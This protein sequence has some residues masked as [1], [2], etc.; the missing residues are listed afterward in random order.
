VHPVQIH[1][2]RGKAAAGQRACCAVLRAMAARTRLTRGPGGRRK[3]S[4]TRR[5]S[6]RGGTR[7]ART[8]DGAE[9][10]KNQASMPTELP[11]AHVQLLQLEAVSSI[12][13]ALNTLRKRLESMRLESMDLTS[14]IVRLQVAA[15]RTEGVLEWI[16]QVDANVSGVPK[17]YFSPRSAPKVSRVG[18]S[19]RE[20]IEP[21]REE[22]A[23]A[24]AGVGASRIWRGTGGETFDQTVCRS[25]HRHLPDDIP[26]IQAFGGT[27]FD[28]R[29]RPG[30]EWEE[31]GSY[32]FMLPIL[33]CREAP[34]CTLVSC[35]VVWDEE[36]GL[37]LRFQQSIDRCREIVDRCLAS[38]G[39]RTGASNSASTSTI[40]CPRATEWQ[41][42]VRGMLRRLEANAAGTNGGGSDLAK[43]V[44]ARRTQ[45]IIPA[46]MDPFSTLA[47]LQ[48]LDPRAYQFCLQLPS[49]T[50]FFGS[51]PERLFCKTGSK[52]ASE[53]M[54]GTRPRAQPGNSKA[55]LALALDLMLSPKEHAEFSV[56]QDAVQE[57]LKHLC[58]ADSVRLEIEKEV[59]KQASV[60]H[61]YSRLSGTLLPHTSEDKIISTLHPTPAVCGFPREAARKAILDL[62][63]FDRGFYAGPFGWIGSR[64][65]E[66][67]VAIRS[68]L[69]VGN[70]EETRNRIQ[71]YAGVGI[72]KS[73]DPTA[74]WDELD[75]KIR[76]YEKVLTCQCPLPEEPNPNSL[77]ARMI[78]EELCRL[79]VRYFC[80]AP[81]SRST[82][83]ALAVARNPRASVRT[84]LDERSLCFHSLGFSR[85][86]GKPA[87]V[88]T[89][90]GTA[91][92]NLL[93]AVVEAHESSIPMLV[94][95]AD[96][97]KE[98]LDNGS[99]QTIH[100]AGIFG[101]NVRYECDLP[102]ATD[103]IPARMLLTTV[104]QAVAHAVGASNRPGP[105]HLNCPFR[106]PL[107]P[108]AI[109]WRETCLEGL[110]NWVAS[111]QPFTRINFGHQLYGNSIEDMGRDLQRVEKGII[112]VGQSTSPRVP[113]SALKL[114]EALGWPVVGD[115][116]SGLRMGH[117][118]GVDA[119]LVSFADQVLLSQ[120]AQKRLRPQTIIQFG[121]HLVS[122]RIQTFLEES[123]KSKCGSRWIFVAPSWERHDP[124]HV[125]T[126]RI[127]MPSE[128]FVDLIVEQIGTLRPFW[129]DLD[130]A[131]T[132]KFVDS[133]VE[134]QVNTCLRWKEGLT[135]AHVANFVSKMLP[136]GHALFLGNSMPIRD[137]DM[138]ADPRR[139]QGSSGTLVAANRGAS[140]IDGVLSTACGYAVGLRTPATLVIG[141]ASFLHDTNGLLFLRDVPD[142]YP[143][144]VV[145]VNNGGGS[146]F[147]Y[148]PVAREVSKDVFETMFVV[149]TEDVD[150]GMLCQ[151]HCTYHEKV[152]C[153]GDFLQALERSWS[154]SGH[155]VIEVQIDKADNLKFHET[156]KNSIE[157]ALNRA[158]SLSAC[159]AVDGNGCSRAS[160][161]V[162]IG[163]AQVK[164]FA[165]PL[166][167]SLTVNSNSSRDGIIIELEGRMPSCSNGKHYKGMG[168][169]S[170]LPG[171]HAESIQQVEDQLTFI[172]N[173]INKGGIQVPVNV[174]LLDGS[175]DAWLRT[176][177]GR[178]LCYFL[179]SVRFG[180]ESAVL[181][182]L[183]NATERNLGSLIAGGGTSPSIRCA[184]LIGV[185]STAAEGQD[186]ALSLVGEGYSCV[187]VKVGRN[188]NVAEDIALLQSIRATVG[189][190]VQLRCDANR[191]WSLEEALYFGEGVESCNLEYVEE[192]CRSY[193]DSLDFQRMSGIPVAFDETVDEMS[194]SSN[195]GSAAWD[196]LAGVSVFVLKPSVLGGLE[197]TVQLFRWAQLKGIRCVVSSSFEADVG[198][199]VLVHLSAAIDAECITETAHGL[200]TLGW[201]AGELVAD[202]SSPSVCQNGG[203]R[204][205]L[206][207]TRMS[208][209]E[210][211]KILQGGMDILKAHVLADA[212]PPPATH[213][214]YW[215]VDTAVAR[216][217]FR[218]CEIGPGSG[219][220][221]RPTLLFLHGFLGC[222][223]DWL[224]LMR[225]LSSRFRCIS[226]DLPGHG[227]SRVLDIGSAVSEPRV[228]GPFSAPE[229]NDLLEVLQGERVFEAY[230]LPAV[231]DALAALM[232]IFGGQCI[233]VGYSMG[234]RI[235]LHASIHHQDVVS[236]ACLVSGSPGVSDPTARA[237]RCAE[238]D[239]RARTIRT[240]G[241]SSFVRRWYASSMW[242]SMRTHPC[243]QEVVERRIANGRAAA[244]ACAVSGLSPGR[245]PDLWPHLL[246]SDC[247]SWSQGRLLFVAGARDASYMRVLDR[248]SSCGW[249]CASVEGAGHALPL[250]AP[251]GLLSHLVRWIQP[252]PSSPP[253]GTWK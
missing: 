94:L 222:K 206:G 101:R 249:S 248:L 193:L 81:G 229:H 123:C 87:V 21:V 83:L 143:V 40:H 155:S 135:E 156:M 51:T 96:R 2:R 99:N 62:E 52:V 251:L 66:F 225:P 195:D 98:L 42:L 126:D 138:Y 111:D 90:S 175:L 215:S 182:L 45:T 25:I 20:T 218:V 167:Q 91:V 16:R 180:L 244:L 241:V 78:V 97:P 19:G 44:L 136:E 152:C 54:A 213:E 140:G 131:C 148:L 173:R 108:I 22:F 234:A 7:P 59:V 159:P 144:T 1:C 212:C 107:A 48:E 102:S 12:R 162:D 82:P 17:V 117:L 203:R 35:T 29:A 201:F 46:S 164:R 30:L 204:E 34:G 84:C 9:T 211:G 8:V 115:V 179:P 89:T 129:R 139:S 168:E 14:G 239:L 122:K 71:L 74:E 226:V 64:N 86:R 85:G 247:N 231:S 208:L 23:G 6:E 57:A 124:G 132:W 73:A 250:E 177:F 150:I 227:E 95:T 165:L 236:S 112:V 246:A 4:C 169:T 65:A 92:A 120:D 104:D 238:D 146:I 76:Q 237:T 100:Q 70:K 114:S 161:Y 80:V 106:E 127:Q 174:C 77:W 128:V 55:D 199:S 121:G 79:G 105:V 10:A 49:G 181:S 53:S 166:K 210:G 28:C 113:F 142:Q 38:P 26:N 216:Y 50:A 220:S 214:D 93:P 190:S 72:V 151:A 3:V 43:V 171:L 186:R 153:V 13:E 147:N 133:A 158:L 24:T 245:Q 230:A 157:K 228:S 141:D 61:L 37:P 184:G 240:H 253:P 60:Q 242:D 103:E 172:C 109:Q 170:P 252:P 18:Q 219:S 31:F 188:R 5:K 202:R 47:A 176:V 192:P 205:I 191:A 160:T 197:K 235:A 116:A 185:C 41:N 232:A 154:M 187:K 36:E 217:L 68:A 32:Y 125:L 178:D 39:E 149:P 198:M 63:P 196:T 27:R 223:E 15:P 69:L 33:E 119:C 110:E 58:E 11:I 75:L 88:I 67:S 233:C 200:G 243:F 189:P 194:T 207:G 130:Y 134:K 145:V 209:L 221:E 56:V 163:M 118:A 137:F 224:P 183:A